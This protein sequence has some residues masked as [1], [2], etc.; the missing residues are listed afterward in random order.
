[1]GTVKQQRVYFESLIASEDLHRATFKLSDSGGN[2][3]TTFHE[4]FGGRFGNDDSGL[5]VDAQS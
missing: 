3:T 5:V 4:A 2:V 1:M